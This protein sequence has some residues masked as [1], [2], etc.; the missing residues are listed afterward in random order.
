MRDPFN[1]LSS[2][3][4]SFLNLITPSVVWVSK[5]FA[6]PPFHLTASWHGAELGTINVTQYTSAQYILFLS[7]ATCFD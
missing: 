7:K 6:V 5:V 3:L 1:T 4:L 2:V